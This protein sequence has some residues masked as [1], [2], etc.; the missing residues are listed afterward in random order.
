M[1]SLR[2]LCNYGPSPGLAQGSIQLIYLT[3]FAQYM[4]VQWLNG[5][6]VVLWYCISSAGASVWLIVKLRPLMCNEHT[7]MV[8]DV[9][10]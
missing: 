2:P 1:P 6:V 3:L 5:A 8:S 4:G 9:C 7:D 10:V